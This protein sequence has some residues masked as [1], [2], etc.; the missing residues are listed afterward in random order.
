M[1]VTRPA[2]NKLMALLGGMILVTA[3]MLLSATTAR[4]ESNPKQSAVP[5]QPEG[6]AVCLE[7]HAKSDHMTRSGKD[8]SVQVDPATYGDSVHGVLSCARCHA[9]AAGPEHAKDPKKPLAVPAAGTRERKVFQSL[10]C[11]KCHAGTIQDSYNYSF[12]GVASQHGD[13]RAATCVDC[14]GV[15]NILP[16]SNP[17]SQVAP[18]KVAQTCGQSGCHQNAPA[19][20]AAG[21]EHYVPSD[22]QSAGAL[23]IIYKMFMGLIMFDVMKDGPIVMFEL[24]RRLQQH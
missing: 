13:T 20:F 9:E 12:H 1:N 6:N 23:N 4:A 10:E 19:N 18:S 16:A 5:T 17:A 15:H 2:R 21:K 8:I 3:G 24:L 7:C 11:V 14:H 22:K